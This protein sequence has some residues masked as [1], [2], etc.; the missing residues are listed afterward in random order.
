M[1]KIYTFYLMITNYIVFMIII[2]NKSGI[3]NIRKA[4]M[5]TIKQKEKK[6]NIEKTFLNI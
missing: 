1:I 5:K 6:M 4:N 3:K 2:N